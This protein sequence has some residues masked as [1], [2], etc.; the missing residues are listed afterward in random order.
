MKDEKILL[1][2]GLGLSPGTAEGNAC[3]VENIADL[4]KLKEGMIMIAETSNPAWTEGMMRA[5]GF[6][7]ERGGIICHAAIVARELGLPCMVGI[8]DILSK[9]RD[10]QPILMIVEGS[11]GRLYDNSTTS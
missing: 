10:H 4:D 7:C 8:K 9:I 6:I 3:L 11:E 2:T 1:A 5:G